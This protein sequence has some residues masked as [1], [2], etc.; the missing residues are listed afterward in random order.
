MGF[1]DRI[2]ARDVN[3]ATS[4]ARYAQQTV[5]VAC[6]TQLDL[7][8]LNKEITKFKKR[9]PHLAENPW[10]TLVRAAQWCRSQR[11]RPLKTSWI[12][13][14]GLQWAWQD[15]ALP[16]LDPIQHRDEKTEEGIAYALRYERDPRWRDRLIGA[17]GVAREEVLRAWRR[18]SHSLTH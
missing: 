9:Y 17:E 15:G 7:M 12:V 2:T 13:G 3:S 14:K 8:L 4:F 1:A 10:P 16:E 6:S 5:G 18:S 11:K